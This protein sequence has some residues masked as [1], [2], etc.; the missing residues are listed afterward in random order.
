MHLRLPNSSRAIVSF[1][2]LFWYRLSTALVLVSDL[3]PFWTLW[4]TVIEE[5]LVPLAL[6]G[7]PV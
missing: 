1:A 4:V 2:V 3:V 7:E 5:I 6:W